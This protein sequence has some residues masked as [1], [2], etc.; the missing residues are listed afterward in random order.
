MIEVVK[1]LSSCLLLQGLSLVVGSLNGEDILISF[2]GYNGRYN[3]E[4]ETILASS[5]YE[6]MFLFDLLC[7]AVRL[8]FLSQ[9][10]SQP[11]NQR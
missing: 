10:T 8:M 2:G 7:F 1:L 5:V 3:S 11:C 6:F 4:V 9:V